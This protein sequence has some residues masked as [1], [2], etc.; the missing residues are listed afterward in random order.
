VLI[1]RRNRK[2]LIA[3]SLMLFEVASYSF[4]AFVTISGT[5]RRA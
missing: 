4:K 2:R 1:L 3:L 5:V